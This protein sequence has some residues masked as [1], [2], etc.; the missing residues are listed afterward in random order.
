MKDSSALPISSDIPAIRPQD[1]KGDWA[2]L[3]QKCRYRR[4]SLS[5]LL[6]VSSRTLDR[7]FKKYLFT[8]VG[9][10]LGE[11]RLIEAYQQILAGKSLKEASF[12]TGFKQASHFSRTFKSRFGILPSMLRGTPREVLRARVRTA[13][14]NQT[15]TPGC[16]PDP[17]EPS[18]NGLSAR[19]RLTPVVQVF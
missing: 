15:M 13:A 3:A 2:V 19:G 4:E 17:L 18:E 5:S 16:V 1:E 9:I 6:Q 7:Y 11:L 8:T 10:W 14:T 12:A